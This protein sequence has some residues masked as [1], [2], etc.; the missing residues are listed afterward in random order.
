MMSIR[1]TSFLLAQLS[2]KTFG[3]SR[4]WW[5]NKNEVSRNRFLVV[6]GVQGGVL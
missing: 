1:D 6:T 2:S 4:G 5:I 3:E